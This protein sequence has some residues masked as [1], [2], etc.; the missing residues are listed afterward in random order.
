MTIIWYDNKLV[1]LFLNFDSVDEFRHGGWLKCF[2]ALR[3]LVSKFRYS[4][5]TVDMEGDGSTVYGILGILNGID[6][7]LARQNFMSVSIDSFPILDMWT[8]WFNIS[9]SFE[10]FNFFLQWSY[11]STLVEQ[12]LNNA[13][14]SAQIILYILGWVKSYFAY[15]TANIPNKPNEILRQ[16]N[17]SV[18]YYNCFYVYSSSYYCTISLSILASCL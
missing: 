6:R 4:L 16:L 18:I 5:V 2:I 17:I 8:Y 14:E 15:M 3:K 11:S 12:G 9:S 13:S 10:V 7:S 1:P